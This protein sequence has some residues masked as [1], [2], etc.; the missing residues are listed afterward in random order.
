MAAENSANGN[1]SYEQTWRRKTRQMETLVMNKLIAQNLSKGNLT[2]E[3][4]WQ[5]KTRQMETLVRNKH[6]DTKL[7]KWKP[8]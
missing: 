6:G 5:R 7:G 3:Q 2:N 4:T 1:F 8:Y